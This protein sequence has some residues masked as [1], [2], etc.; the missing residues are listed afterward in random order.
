MTLDRSSIRLTLHKRQLTGS[1]RLF[2]A[3]SLCGGSLRS[4]DVVDIINDAE[5]HSRLCQEVNWHARSIDLSHWHGEAQSLN[6]K[7][8]SIAKDARWDDAAKVWDELSEART[9]VWWMTEYRDSKLE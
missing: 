6:G 4:R 9:F 2:D 7:Y 5:F 3:R 8:S 1:C